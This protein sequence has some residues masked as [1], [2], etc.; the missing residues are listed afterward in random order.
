MKQVLKFYSPTCGPCRVMANNLSKLSDVEI[1][2]IDV[3][4]ES[5]EAEIEKWKITTIPTTIFL[6]EEG[7]LIY[8]FQGIVPLRDL[9]RLLK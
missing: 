1:H 4:D 6:N 9:E 8:R 5:N 3:T 2:N 7:E